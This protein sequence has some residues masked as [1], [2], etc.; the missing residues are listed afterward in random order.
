MT[1]VSQDDYKSYT[2]S[3]W[4]F[5]ERLL[6][7]EPALTAI[8]E[9]LINYFKENVSP[10][11]SPFTIWQAHKTVVRGMCIQWGARLK[12]LYMT[13]RVTILRN[14]NDIDTRNKAS[15][16]PELADE[17]DAA[18]RSLTD[19]EADKYRIA[20]NRMRAKFYAFQNKPGRLLARRLKPSPPNVGISHLKTDGGIIYNP[21]AMA[22]E[23]A[24]YYEKLYNLE[25][26]DTNVHPTSDTI[27]AYLRNINLPKLSATQANKLASPITQEE[28]SEVIKALPKRKAPGP[29]GL[30][31]L[32][33]LTFS[34]QLFT[35][36][37]K[38][39]EDARE[40]GSFPPDMLR[41]HIITLPK[42]GKT[43]DICRNL[44]PISLLNVDIKIYSKILA[45]RLQRILPS[46]IGQ[47]QVG[48]ISGRQGPD[49][50]KKL[51]N[52]M[53]VL[54][55]LGQSCLV[56][57]LDAEKA[58]DRVSWL[59]LRVVL[60]KFG[61]PPPV[62]AA[63]QALYD[64]PSARV[65]NSG[66]LSEE[67]RITNGTRQ[68][69]P[70]SPLLYALVLEPLAQAI[71]QNNDIRGIAVGPT[72]HKIHLYAD[73]ILLTLTEPEASLSA[74]YGELEV[75]SRVSYHLVNLLKTQ[76][77][78]L[79][80]P[81]QSL[82]NLKMHYNF[83]WRKTYLVYLGL[84][85]TGHPDGLYKHNYERVL[86]ETRSLIHLWRS[87]EVSW[88][89]RMA[90]AKMVILPK[91]LYVFRA[92]PLKLPRSFLVTLQSILVSYVWNNKRPRIARRLLCYRQRD[93]GLNM[94]HIQ[95]YFWA[96]C[97]ASLSEVF[98]SRPTPQWL[99]IEAAYM[100]GHDLAKVLWVPPKDRPR[101][102]SPLATTS[103]H[104]YIWDRI[105]PLITY[106]H[107]ISMAMP[108]EALRYIL[109]QGRCRQWLQYGI[110]NLH[111]FFDTAAILPFETICTKFKVPQT[112]F[113]SYLQL[114]SYFRS[115]SVL[116]KLRAT[117]PLLSET[118]LFCLDPL[119]T[120]RPISLFYRVLNTPT[121]TVVWSFQN[122]WEKELGRKFTPTQWASAFM[123]A[124]GATRCVTLI[125]TQRKIL[126][127]W[128]LTPDKIK[129]FAPQHS[130]LCW[131]CSLETGSM[132]HIWWYCPRIA[133]LWRDI[134]SLATE[135]LGTQILHSPEVLLLGIIK[136]PRPQLRML[137]IL[138]ST[139]ALLLARN[140]R[141]MLVPT[142]KQVTDLL[143][144]YRSFDS[145][146]TM[147]EGLHSPKWDPWKLWDV[148]KIY[149]ACGL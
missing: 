21:M 46:L 123:F 55:R 110:T 6:K 36:L 16:T 20:M 67:F 19:L 117:L 35:H 95:H 147:A 122:T 82:D 30:T 27:D 114:Q 124:V 52:L 22:N 11:M 107:P 113:L 99:T 85:I 50:M 38:V 84:R 108:V 121:R 130:D 104:L 148:H 59:F 54:R 126:Y 56:L 44:R 10:E 125:E 23:F 69:C 128:Y 143:E 68:G 149:K 4:R 57:S 33:Y 15:P 89:G 25:V 139:T 1:I 18:L 119:A 97:L 53:E 144:Q 105:F 92:L 83:E 103:L 102:Q 70:L 138:I 39:F 41:A 81:H 78:P 29:D 109:P 45:N 140:W 71:R 91:L 43:P 76:G 51:I 2:G 111:H 87:R 146:I 136:L 131:R 101:F 132:S 65:V 31:D 47:D 24:S 90:A 129:R 94:I 116:S 86:S 62:L 32:Y 64:S 63:I 133:P 142:C 98:H 135:I 26:D 9:T 49:S 106:H 72:I 3:P 61:F 34:P 79:N 37:S 28:L 118:E 80:I 96:S 5:G 48:F 13:Q 42:P 115:Q 134:S 58:F 8:R 137:F 40:Q 66:F 77:L 127:R 93:G 14:I 12:K 60:Q 74:L 73:D 120:A 141:T 88:M 145:R 112:M 75:Y 17:F 7:H 100:E